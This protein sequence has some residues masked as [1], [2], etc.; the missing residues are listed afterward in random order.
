MSTTLLDK[1]ISKLEKEFFEPDENFILKKV[2]LSNSLDPSMRSASYIKMT[3]RKGLSIFKGNFEEILFSIHP[4]NDNKFIIFPPDN[5]DGYF[6][7]RALAKILKTTGKTVELIRVPKDTV[8]YAVTITAG[9]KSKNIDLDYYFPVHVVSTKSVTQMKGAKFHKF[10][11]KV[12][13]CLKSG[14]SAKKIIFDK[15][16]L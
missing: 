9:K 10:R 14:A 7:V 1:N 13:A 11:N 2:I 12:N 15:N 6:D 4:N 5:K 3:G 8:M 16:D